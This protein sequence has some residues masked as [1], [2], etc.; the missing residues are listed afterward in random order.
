MPATPRCNSNKFLPWIAFTLD[1]TFS[2]VIFQSEDGDIIDCIDIYKQPAF[3]HPALKNHK[4]QVCALNFFGSRKNP[5][6]RMMK[7]IL[8]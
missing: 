5:D 6:W 8:L 1:F 7:I 3:N 4:I 2:S